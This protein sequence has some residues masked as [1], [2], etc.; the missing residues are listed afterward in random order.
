MFASESEIVLPTKGIHLTSYTIM[1]F[2]DLIGNASSNILE[3]LNHISNARDIY[4]VSVTLPASHW[5]PFASY[6]QFYCREIPTGNSE[7]TLMCGSTTA[8]W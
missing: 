6:K 1:M 3:E 5:D 4:A 8:L 2:G 7:E